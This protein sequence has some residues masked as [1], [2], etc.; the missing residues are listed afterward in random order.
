MD[1]MLEL[2]EKMKDSKND[3]ETYLIMLI[4]HQEKFFVDKSFHPLKYLLEN[5]QEFEVDG[6]SEEME[7]K[8]CFNNAFETMTKERG[9]YVEGYYCKYIPII[10]AWNE[11]LDGRIVDN[12][13]TD[14]EAC[15]WAKWYGI[16]IP[17]QIVLMAVEHKAWT[18]SCG[19]LETINHFDDEDMKKVKEIFEINRWSGIVREFE[20]GT[21]WA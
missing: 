17:L 10:H 3:F 4:H 8:M 1:E 15:E 21:Q 12:T 2:N 7:Q 19:M 18:I 14:K 9:F 16:R 13:I 6:Y 11:L 5:Y 20:E